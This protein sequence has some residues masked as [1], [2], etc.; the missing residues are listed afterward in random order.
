MIGA[1]RANVNRALATL[2][3]KGLV[4][5]TTPHLI[6]LDLEGLRAAGDDE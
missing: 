2:A 1:S 5:R 3:S 4:A 6:L